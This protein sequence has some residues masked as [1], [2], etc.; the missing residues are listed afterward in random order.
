MMQ[1]MPFRSIRSRSLSAAVGC[2]AMLLLSPLLCRAA[3]PSPPHLIV[4]IAVDQFSADLYAEYRSLYTA[5]L[6]RLSTGVVYPAGY[7]SHAATETCPGHATILTGVHPARSGIIANEWF[8]QS[9]ARADKQVYCAEDPSVPGS[10]SNHY[11]VSAVQLKVPTLGDRL[12]ATTPTTRV[13]SVSGKDRAAVMLG[14]HSA[15]ALWY[16]NG[17]AYVSL[18]TDPTRAAAQATQSPPASSERVN[19]HVTA[20]LANPT[21]TALPAGCQSHAIPLTVGTH[22][23]GV[24]LTPSPP[25]T[26]AFRTSPAFDETTTELAIGLL[27][28]LHLGSGPAT[29]ILAIS[30]SATDYVGHRFGT[31]GGEMCAQ[32]LNVDRNVG[33]IL[34]ALDATHVSYVVVLT[35]DHGGHDAPER[36]Q[37]RGFTDAVRVDPALLPNTL[38]TTIAGQFGLPGS[39]LVGR[40]AFGDVYIASSVPAALRPQVLSATLAAYNRH[41]QV[42]ATYTASTLAGM[43]SPSN[44]VDEWSLAERFSA[45]FDPTRSGD[46][47]VALRP[48]VTPIADTNGSLA[49]H[50]SP[51]N[52]D[53]RV[54]ILFYWPGIHGFEQPLPVETVD[55]VPTLAALIGFPLPAADTDGRCLALQE[56][57]ANAC[58]RAAQK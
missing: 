12:K 22:T 20:W 46:V 49:T 9:L 52:Y 55:I 58:E 56:G 6:R 3:A 35:A 31:A 10:S 1:S 33:A 48:H 19:A 34:N 4:V 41:P 5:G 27:Q 37:Q 2:M 42:A 45:S 21:P 28:D 53:R 57:T 44:P 7:Q 24:P 18:T 25:S 39:A 29:D 32:V 51:W 13:V 50:G 38:G 23:V 14:G 40:S 11:T 15:D 16:F 54:P 43:K 8:D 36:N 30:L 47:L 26:Q 17:S